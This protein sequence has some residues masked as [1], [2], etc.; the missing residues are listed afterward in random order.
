MNYLYAL[1]PLSLKK[2]LLFYEHF[3]CMHACTCAMSVSGARKGPL[4]LDLWTA[5]RHHASARN[6]TWVSA[7]ALNH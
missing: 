4:E 1:L 2:M 5:M 6:Q 3:A 7:S